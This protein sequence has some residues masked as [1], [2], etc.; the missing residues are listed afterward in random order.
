M[1]FLTFVGTHD[2]IGPPSTG[3][4]A[5]L[6]IFLEYR[7]KIDDVYIFVTSASGKADFHDIARKIKKVMESEAPTVNVHLIDVDIIDPVDYD[8]VYQ[9][10]FDE[11]Q[12]LLK[13]GEFGE[14]EKIINITSGTPTMTAC[15]IL[16]Q[17]SGLVP[18]ATLIQSSDPQ[19]RKRVEDGEVVTKPSTHK[20]NLEIDNFPQIQAPDEI[21]RKLNLATAEL[22]AYKEEKEL[23]DLDERAPLLVGESKR[24]RE[25][26]EQILYEIDQETHVLILGEPGTGK[27]IV[28]RSIWDQHRKSIDKQMVT[29]DCGQFVPNLIVSELFGYE[30]GA[31]TG[32]DQPRQGIVEANDGRMIFLD[33]IGN[34]PSI[35]RESLCGSSRTANGEKSAETL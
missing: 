8:L 15:W 26:K 14:A 33:E 17:K 9:T 18:N 1:K 32:A 23:R 22:S 20:V 34:I 19:F 29:F 12:E 16:L 31:F 24:I 3:Y 25:I 6:T 10:L 5:V 11:T 28:A 21:K 13:D 27:E 4:G 2:D 7:V 35:I 30:R